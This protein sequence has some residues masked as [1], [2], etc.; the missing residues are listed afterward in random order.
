MLTKTEKFSCYTVESLLTALNLYEPYRHYKAKLGTPIEVSLITEEN[1]LKEIRL[2]PL[3]TAS[4]SSRKP[5]PEEVHL[6]FLKLKEYCAE[7]AGKGLPFLNNGLPKHQNLMVEGSFDR[8]WDT[9]TDK[10]T[11][12]VIHSSGEVFVVVDSRSDQKYSP[13]GLLG[14]EFGPPVVTWENEPL[15]GTSSDL[16]PPLTREKPTSLGAQCELW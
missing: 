10:C 11:S 6:A 2:N 13:S 14:W 5:I 16:I 12:R 7:L 1:T 9:E 8:T 4:P 15:K 3:Q